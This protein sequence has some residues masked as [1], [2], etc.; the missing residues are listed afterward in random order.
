ML[1]PEELAVGFG[2]P[3]RVCLQVDVRGE[4]AGGEAGV[5]DAVVVDSV[6]GVAACAVTVRPSE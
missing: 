5:A 3:M 4:E 6:A 1:C 2:L